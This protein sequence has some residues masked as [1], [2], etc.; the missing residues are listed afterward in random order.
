MI[1]D[2]HFKHEPIV[3]PETVLPNKE[4]GAISKDSSAKSKATARCPA[5]F[6]KPTK[7]WPARSSPDT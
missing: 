6:T 1:I 2:I 5:C 3:I 7:Q 4:I